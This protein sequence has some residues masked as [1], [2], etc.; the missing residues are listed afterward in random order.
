[1][2]ER[3]SLKEKSI[4]ITGGTGSFGKQVAR[5]LLKDELCEKVVI[6]SRDEW[7]QSEMQKMDPIFCSEK[8]RYFLGDVRDLQ[9]LGRAFY[10]I[11]IVIHAAALKQ[12]PAAEY[13]PSEFVKTNVQGA[14]NV[15]DM[16]IERGVERVIALSTDK[17]VNPVNLYGATKLCSDKLFIAGNAY[18]GRREKPLFSIV[19]YGNVLGS[20]GSVIPRW[21]DLLKQ[22]NLSIPI[23]DPNMTRF[24]ITLDYAVAFVLASLK[25]MLGA[26][27]FVPKIPSLSIADLAK[28]VAPEASLQTIGAR[29][30]EKL[31]EILINN[32]EAAYTVDCGSY[33]VI[34]PPVHKKKLEMRIQPY[35]HTGQLVS[36]DFIYTSQSNPDWLSI[37]E[38]RH[39]LSQLLEH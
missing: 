14:S 28:A 36:S 38:V 13:N 23:T 7:K 19:R 8:I 17:S 31:H 11:D 24:W 20:R 6:F 18:V 33:Y 16:A 4:L 34:L 26:E 12:V 32:D 3:Y 5:A 35:L 39:L 2:I 15:I 21:I 29:E 9:R 22:G 30:G 1:M 25:R 37:E 27:I 10:D